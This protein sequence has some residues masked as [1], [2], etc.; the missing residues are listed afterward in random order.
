[1]YQPMP[2]NY[3]IKNYQ[4]MKSPVMLSFNKKATIR[5]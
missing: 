5:R 1:M 2:L 4:L 3:N